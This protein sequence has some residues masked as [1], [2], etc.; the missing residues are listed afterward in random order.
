MCRLLK[1]SIDNHDRR[2]SQ[3]IARR[4]ISYAR[5]C[6][7]VVRG[8]YSEVEYKLL[9]FGYYKLSLLID[10]LRSETVYFKKLGNLTASAVS[11]INANL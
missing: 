11:I 2:R 10:I 7:R 5:F 8:Y 4:W 1:T 3:R 6:Y 9:F